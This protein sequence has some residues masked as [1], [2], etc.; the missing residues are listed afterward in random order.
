MA[1]ACLKQSCKS[2]RKLKP[3][4]KKSSPVQVPVVPETKTVYKKLVSQPLPVVQQIIV[5][6][7]ALETLLQKKVEEALA[8]HDEEQK[9]SESPAE[10]AATKAEVAVIQKTLKNIAKKV[11]AN[12]KSGGAGEGLETRFG[13]ASS[14]TDPGE[15]S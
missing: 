4:H 1:A 13:G 15:W 12:E 11:Q 9:P 7:D 5:S 6:E 2:V 14:G 10:E 8:K 3:V